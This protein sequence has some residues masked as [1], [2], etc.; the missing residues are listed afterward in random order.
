M[1]NESNRRNSPPLRTLPLSIGFAQR[2]VFGGA[3]YDKPHGFVGVKLAPEVMADAMIELPIVDFSVP[4]DLNRVNEVVWAV[5]NHVARKDAVYVG[6]MGGRGRT[7]LFFALLTKAVGEPD[8]IGYVRG[9][10]YCKAI[11]TEAQER[12]VSLYNPPF[13][14]LDMVSLKLRALWSGL[15]PGDLGL[16]A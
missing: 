10:Y 3:Y 2:V 8:P 4:R 9:N 15:Q 14:R 12:Y 16:H 6:C 13:T 5:L 11:E 1:L 7:G